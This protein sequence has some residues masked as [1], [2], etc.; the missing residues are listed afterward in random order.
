[1]SILTEH[2]GLE[3]TPATLRERGWK[4][5]FNAARRIDFWHKRIRTVHFEIPVDDPSKV[6]V[7]QHGKDAMYFDVPDTIL[8]LEG[9]CK[10]YYE[11]YTGFEL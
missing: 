8:E 2:A 7:F 3:L 9:M 4:L 1:M 5:S 11:R 6:R 10:E